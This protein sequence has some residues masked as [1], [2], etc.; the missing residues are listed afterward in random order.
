MLRFGY[1]LLHYYTAAFY[2]TTLGLWL[3]KVWLLCAGL[4]AAVYYPLVQQ[5]LQLLAP[6]HVWLLCT[7][8]LYCTPVAS[9]E[10][11]YDVYAGARRRVGRGV[12]VAGVE[13]TFVLFVVSF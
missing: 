1:I 11:R 5:G 6:S 13:R 4:M 7:K 12:L 10:R 9:T 3:R 8:L 2:S